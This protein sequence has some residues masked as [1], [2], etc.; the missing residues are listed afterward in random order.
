MLIVICVFLLLKY[1]G[2]VVDTSICHPSEFDFYLC[3]HAGIKV[4]LRHLS[5]RHQVFWLCNI[6]H[7]E[8]KFISSGNKQANTLSCP[9]WWEPFLGWCSAVSHKQPLLHVSLTR[10]PLTTAPTFVLLYLFPNP[11]IFG[12]IWTR[13]LLFCKCRYARCTRAVSVGKSNNL[14]NLFMWLAQY[15]KFITWGD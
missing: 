10:L 6:C 12:A 5:L 4:W 3:S 2:T 15:C 11:N 8:C 7:S 13:A 9:L 14:T 1:T